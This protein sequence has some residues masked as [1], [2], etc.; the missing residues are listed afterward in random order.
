MDFI[1]RMK[2]REF[3]EMGLKTLAAILAG[4]IAIILMEG[5]IYSIYMN[6]INNNKASQYVVSDCIAYCK[7]IDSDEYK[8]Y[9]HNINQNSWVIKTI[10]SSESEIK[11][12]GYKDVKWHT[13]TVFDVAITN[14][15]Y[16]VMAIFIVGIGGVYAWR[17]YK[18]NTEYSKMEKKF[19]K[20]GK[21]F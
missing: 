3:I 13:P 21:I 5:M 17:F 6:K 12:A 1:K 14:S 18:I 4:F 19:K 15:H 8:V 11:E 16:I 10:N 20:T 7:K 2:K 9:L